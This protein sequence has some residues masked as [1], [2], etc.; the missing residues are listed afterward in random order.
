MLLECR[1]Q[2]L[3]NLRLLTDDSS[4]AIACRTL[5]PPEEPHG[6]YKLM[7]VSVF[8]ERPVV[9]RLVLQ[10]RFT[11]SVYVG[12]LQASKRALCILARAG[13]RLSRQCLAT[14]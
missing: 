7:H 13:E 12:P 8:A 10:D 5:G 14:V 6:D 3:K 11:V 4:P 1:G 2:K 9:E